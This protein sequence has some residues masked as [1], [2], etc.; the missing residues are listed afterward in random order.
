M[1]FILA[2]WEELGL[3]QVRADVAHVLGDLSRET[4][5]GFAVKVPPELAEGQS[6]V[7]CCRSATV[8]G[9]RGG[10]KSPRR[11]MARGSDPTATKIPRAVD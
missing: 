8:T 2:N 1:G 5:D 7:V 6:A 9:A 11:P 4:T 3:R 10:K